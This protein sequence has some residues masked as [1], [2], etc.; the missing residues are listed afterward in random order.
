MSGALAGV[1]IVD[2]SRVLGG[3]LCTQYLGDHGAEVIKIEPPQGDETRGWGPFGEGGSAY[4][5]GINRN[6]R[7]AALDLSKAQGREVLF[8]LLED[9][10]VL[11]HNFK[12][13]TLERWGIG[14]DVV[15]AERFPR[16]VYCHVTGFGDDG[17][18]GG[19]PGYDS[20]VQAMAGC[21]STNG[22]PD[23]GPTRV[24]M[25]IVDIG[26]ALNATIA[27]LMALHERARS[28]MG[29][30]LDVCLYDC[31]LTFLHPHAV[32]YLQAGVEPMRTGNQH[33]S[34]APYEQF[35][36]A[37]G[38]IFLGVGNDGQFAAV[39][40]VLGLPDLARDERFLTNPKR[41]ENR[42][43]LREILEPRLAEREAEELC[44]LLLNRNIPAGPVLSV[45]EVLAAPHT[46]Y[47]RMV[48]EDGA[49][50]ALG[51]PIKLSRTPGSVRRIPQGFGE[52]SREVC[53]AAGYG[54]REIDALVDAKVVFERR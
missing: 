23:G 2:L 35:E 48:V 52:S 30:K 29:Q 5:S 12:S 54:D 28:G 40:G 50:R 42:R 22:Y 38:P 33:P 46:A 53:R 31:A 25:S 41:V 26:T 47:R 11:I 32:G 1:K 51:I 4:F 45:P 15:L 24:G 17:P 19:L 10:D 18:L 34:I 3:P 9:A 14:Y 13:G 49:Y 8:R 37:T 39:C 36:T 44:T 27:I 16:L 6:K 20:V 43:A 7:N 21:M